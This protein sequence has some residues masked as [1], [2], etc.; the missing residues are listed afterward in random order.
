MAN[1]SRWHKNRPV[2]EILKQ[3]RE[4]ILIGHGRCMIL[5]NANDAWLRDNGDV[6]TRHDGVIANVSRYRGAVRVS[7]ALAALNAYREV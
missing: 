4:S 5:D 2:R 6:D 7:A 3:N 1:Y